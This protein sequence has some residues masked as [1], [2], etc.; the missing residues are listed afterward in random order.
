[1]SWVRRNLSAAPPG[2]TFRVRRRGS[3]LLTIR[4]LLSVEGHVV[5]DRNMGQA[6]SGHNIQ[7][8]RSANLRAHVP[9]QSPGQVSRMLKRLRTHGLI[10]KIGRT[11]KYY[12][13]SAG[14]A[15]ITTGLKLKN[16][17]LIPALARAMEA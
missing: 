9:E 5:H 17:V 12:V 6:L 1:M 4:R 10:K 16:I 7:G 11:H 3:C 8:F 13:T 15:L 14:R 2:V